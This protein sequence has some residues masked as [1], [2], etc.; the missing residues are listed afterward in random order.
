MIALLL[1]VVAVF[2]SVPVGAVAEGL[3]SSGATSSPS[4]SQDNNERGV[5]VYHNGAETSSLVLLENGRETLTS[6]TR[7]INVSGRSWQ[8]L[9]PDGKDWVSIYGKNQSSLTVTYALVASMLNENGFAYVR[10]RVKDGDS[11]YVSES[12]EIS[13]NHDT[14]SYIDGSSEAVSYANAERRPEKKLLAA[15]QSE[16]HKTYSIVINYIFD[17]GGI[18]YEPYGASVAAGSEFSAE[19]TSPT[20]VGYEPFRRVGN[21]YVDASVVS[22]DYAAVNENITINV[23]Y[24]PGMVE[25]KVH[26]HL[27][28]LNDDD[29]SLTYDFITTGKG[30]TGS[31]VPEGLELSYDELPGFKPLAYEKLTIAADGSTVVEIRYDRDYYLVNFDMKGGFG[32][33]PVYTR[34]G[35]IVGANAPTRHGYLFDGWELISYGEDVPTLEQQA[36]FDINAGTITLPDRNLT[37][38]AKWITQVTN[39]TMVFWKENINDNGFTYWGYL[40]DLRA[41][42]GS[43]VSGENRVSEAESAEDLDQFIY[44]DALTDKNVMVEG[45]GSTIVNVYYTRQRYTLTFKA[46]GLC[47]IK[48]GH[49]HTEACYIAFCDGIHVHGAECERTLACELEEHPSH[50]EDCI[51]CGQTEH[52]HSSA[53]CGLSEHTHSTSCYTGVS[54]Q[55]NPSNAPKNPVNGQIYATGTWWLTYYIYISGRWYRYSGRNASSGDVVSSI[56]G[57]TE[58]QHGTSSC[59][60][61]LSEHTHTDS[62]YR[63]ILHTHVDSCYHYDCGKEE[64]AAHSEACSILN[65]GIPEGHSHT[66]DCL[67]ENKTNVVKIVY[68]KYQQNLGKDPD[69]FENSDPGIWPITDDNGVKYNNGERWKPSG[70]STYDQVMVYL[71]NMPGESFTLT[72][73]DADHVPYVMN[74]YLEVLPSYTGDVVE[75]DG[76]RFIRYTTIEAKYAYLTKAEDF[77]DIKGFIQY[78]SNPVFSN[79]QI[80]ISGN[81]RNVDLYYTRQ[82]DHELTFRSN[83]IVLDD[84]TVT[85]IQYGEKLESYR[86]D[87]PYPSSLEPNAY[88]F[89]GWYTSPGHYDGTEVDWENITMEAGGVMLYAK[90]SPIVHTLSVYFDDSLTQQVGVTQSVPHGNFAHAPEETLVNG[91][92]IFQGWFYKETEADGDVVEKA[93]VFTG[94]PVLK[95]LVIYAKWSSHVTVEYTIN[96]VLH[97]TGEVIA[98]ATTGSA[99]AGHNKTFYAKAGDELNEGFREGYYPLTSSHTVTMSAESDHEFTFEYVYVESMPYAVRYIDEGG[100]E[101]A[102]PKTVMDNNLSVVTET[103]V[104]V[105]KKMPDA[106]QKRLILSADGTDSDGDGILDVN[107]ITFVYT[108]D[109]E[110]AYYRVVHYIENIAKDGYREYRSEDTVG[111]IGQTY[112]IAPISITGFNFNGQLTTVNGVSTPVLSGGISAELGADGLL[113]ELYYDRAPVSYTVKYLESGTGNVLYAEKTVESFFG[114]QVVEYA[115]SLESKGYTLVSDNVKQ[116]HLSM[117]ANVIEFHYQEIFASI[118][119]QLVAPSGAGKLSQ[120]SENVL[121]ISGTPNGSYPILMP[122]YSFVGWYFD[123]ACTHPVNTEWVDPETNH[124]TPEKDGIWETEKIYYAKAVADFTSLTISAVGAESVDR[125]Q[126]FIYR[127]KGTSSESAGIEL[128]VVIIGNSSVTVSHLRVGD[129]TVTE[130]TDWSYRYTPDG[131]EKSISLSVNAADNTLS[132]SHERSDSKWVDSSSENN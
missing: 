42:S 71:A 96:Y 66:K 33:E 20:V 46:P 14:S 2:T 53:C 41:M 128:T 19:I 63:D 32:T 131:A 48:E 74:Y 24:E 26:H 1:S 132:F 112:S 94:I 85:G 77:F 28:N 120:T 17:N 109:E 89:D 92:Y 104:K 29:Y 9:T 98:P 111:L 117:N 95:D 61:T 22:L 106:Y 124:F 73:D 37:Y 102:E 91:N 58:H 114:A 122:G 81:N 21:E 116:L 38:R 83:G 121:A 59:S 40:D 86:F 126:T 10:L 6:E 113:V 127:I 57:K 130:I 49:T 119:Y 107:T 55:A 70:S 62:C 60:C 3:S 43:H 79:N 45:D 65:C 100:N 4:I 76:K 13:V 93:F 8:I 35:S 105:D 54:S 80:S 82:V 108:S 110:H 23:I 64:H 67:N 115:P 34:Y 27:Q 78:K 90:W 36:E 68:K 52:T 30:L 129:Y 39:Y 75:Y 31:I 118:K 72:V 11:Y 47:V 5:S 103:F 97:T 125:G 123:A 44:C 25:F 12:V 84:K 56:C 51:I 88:F 16:E 87:P 18:A 50:T 99:I 15:A 69:N 7:G 101:V